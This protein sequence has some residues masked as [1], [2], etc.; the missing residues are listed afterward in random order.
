[1]R[2]DIMSLASRIVVLHVLGRQASTTDNG[3]AQ[4][5]DLSFKFA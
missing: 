5:Q 1:M 4:A 3:A 2:H